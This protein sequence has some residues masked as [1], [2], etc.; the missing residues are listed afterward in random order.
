[1]G[2]RLRAWAID[3]GYQRKLEAKM[4]NTTEQGGILMM[5]LD[6]TNALYTS[7][8]ISNT[9]RNR[10]IGKMIKTYLLIPTQLTRRDKSNRNNSNKNN[11]SSNQ[12]NNGLNKMARARR[13]KILSVAKR[14]SINTALSIFYY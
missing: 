14:S 10:M 8:L 9:Q 2:G 12:D 4:K 7:H 1:M 13:N 6:D 3:E 5:K 11:N